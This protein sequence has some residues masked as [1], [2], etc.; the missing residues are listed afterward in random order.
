M[1]TEYLKYLGP[2]PEEGLS[3][4][5]KLL[6]VIDGDTIKVEITRTFNVRLLNYSKPELATI[7]GQQAKASLEESIKPGDQLHIFIPAFKSE[8][9]ID[10]TTFNRVLA[11][12]YDKDKMPL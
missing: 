2:C 4:T 10:N 1:E 6:K 11:Y 9:L 5:V 3:T 12:V 8:T 7:E